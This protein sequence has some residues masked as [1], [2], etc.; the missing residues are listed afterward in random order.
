M[1]MRIP[2]RDR[3][4]AQSAGQVAKRSVPARV[5]ALVGTLELDEEAIGTER[6][7]ECGR[8]VRIA[9][10]ETLPRAPGQAHEPLVQLLEPSLVERGRQWFSPLLRSGMRMRGRDQPA[11]VGV[12][13]RGL[14]EQRHV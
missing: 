11:E 7:R 2:G 1:R 4:D 6:A 3:L 5:A 8:R 13:A 12:A 9:H 14:D 10:A